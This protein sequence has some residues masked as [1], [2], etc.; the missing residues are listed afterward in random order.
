MSNRPRLTI[1]ITERQKLFLDNLPFGWKQQIYSALT[2]MLFD[3]VKRCGGSAIGAI[4]GRKI[5]LE[6]YFNG[7]HRG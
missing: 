2:D 4:I 1:D 5:D 7:D 3:M 6:E